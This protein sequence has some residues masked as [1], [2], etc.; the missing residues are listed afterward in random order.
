[1]DVFS[2]SAAPKLDAE[3]FQKAADVLK[4]LDSR[5]DI[6]Q[7]R[8]CRALPALIKH[9]AVGNE[10]LSEVTFQR[11]LDLGGVSETESLMVQ[12]HASQTLS[13]LASYDLY[14][15]AVTEKATKG[16]TDILGSQREEILVVAL[17][18][19][20]SLVHDGI[21]GCSFRRR[22]ILDNPLQKERKLRS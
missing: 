20:A 7:I 6:D 3:Y 5:D 19:L 11:V 8:A 10:I 14:R 2:L 15:P 22:R 13:L 9:A 16:I 18:I 21:F 17:R 12:I 1:M 4:M